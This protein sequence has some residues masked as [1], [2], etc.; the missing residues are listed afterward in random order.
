MF[1]EDLSTYTKP[2]TAEKGPRAEVLVVS[3]SLQSLS[4]PNSFKILAETKTASMEF[5][6][7][8]FGQK[9]SKTDMSHHIQADISRKLT[10]LD[11]TDS[12]KG[13][14]GSYQEETTCENRLLSSF[15]TVFTRNKSACG[16]YDTIH[17][18][19]TWS[20]HASM[21]SSTDWLVDGCMNLVINQCINW[22]IDEP[23]HFSF[24]GANF[25]QLSSTDTK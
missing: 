4:G 14:C 7:S 3:H 1:K 5:L 15:M 6:S 21:N 23:G 25:V 16:R 18:A 17:K 2:L 24:R 22:F 8:A 11:D 13:A 19:M 20:V 12:E 10:L 9:N